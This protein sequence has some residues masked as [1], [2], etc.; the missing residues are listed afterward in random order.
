ME[1]RNEVVL[2]EYNRALKQG[3]REVAEFT[4]Q[5][6]STN[7]AV[8]D[9]I[10]PENNTDAVQD[11]GLLEIPSQRII[12]TKSAGRI[13]AFSPSFLPLLEP[14]SEFA[15]KWMNLCAAHLGDVGIRDAIECYEYLG[16]FYVQEGN[17]RVSV[18]RYFGAP[19]IPAMVKRVVPPK[20]DDPRILAYY[21]FLEFFKASRLY[22][23]QFRRPGCYAKLLSAVGKKPGEVWTEEEKRT[24]NSYYSYF[25]DAFH[26]IPL[27][28]DVLPEE[29]LLLWLQLY[30]YK[31]LGKMGV[32][33]I[34]KSLAALRYDM[35]ASARQEAVQVRTKADPVG[36][37]GV[38]TWISTPVYLNVAFVHQLSPAASGWALGHE[39][40]KDYLQ[41]VL[42]NKLTIK[43]YYNANTPEEADRLLE[44]AVTEGA[45]VVF[46]T[47][48]LLRAATLKAAVK[49]PK[50][51]FLNCS[52]DQPYSSVCSYYGRVYEGKFITGAIAGALAQDNR[53]GYIASYPIYG[54]MA[55]INAFALGAQFTNPRAQIQLRWSC[56]EGNPQADF[57]ADGIRVISNRD[58]PGQ[59]KM[60]LDFCSYGTYLM[61]DKGELISLGS[62]V[63]VWGK[64]YEFVLSSMFS[65]TWKKERSGKEAL[66]Y[67]LGMD[68]GV[69]AVNLS[70]RL[71]TGIKT[72]A[73]FLQDSI[74]GKWLDPFARKITAQDGTVKNDGSRT[75]SPD[76]LLH[77]D[78]LC[79][80][81][82]GE[83]PPLSEILP[84]SRAM[85]EELGIYRPKPLTGT[86]EKI[87]EDPGSVR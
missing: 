3:Q 44:Q 57:F 24:F 23:I 52:V 6:K 79:D 72:M 68:S 69:I 43:S 85:V 28:E 59:S 53:I 60:Y 78:W 32:P 58:A 7:P 30:S 4:A 86:E 67:W 42:G 18:L 76:E 34:R 61:D 35:I 39:Q 40:G 64:F 51:E 56:V 12:G 16:N 77:M 46:T 1:V 48:P 20:S 27:K 81:V 19:R 65:G 63:W 33:A 17:K 55:N 45:Q 83:I 26:Q 71:P 5:G 14:K 82:V 38:L 11:L 13:A 2:D 87:H 29:A 21:E 70:D 25:L 9:D 74:A 22:I 73:Q 54:Q 15:G 84:M 47:A 49:Y 8:L 41:Q 31:D 10:L 62:P 50:V 66:N 37:T 75:F 36:K 80:N